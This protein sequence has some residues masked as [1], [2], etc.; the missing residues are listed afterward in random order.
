MKYVGADGTGSFFLGLMMFCG[1]AYMF[2][3]SIIVLSN[4]HLGFALHTVH[5]RSL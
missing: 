4:F 1:G 5:C 3:E 2:L